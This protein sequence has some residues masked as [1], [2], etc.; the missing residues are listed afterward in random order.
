MHCP[1]CDMYSQDPVTC[2]HCG[3]RLPEAVT[4]PHA[5]RETRSR[6]S[7]TPVFVILALIVVAAAAWWMVS[8]TGGAIPAY[9][10]EGPVV[11]SEQ[12]VPGQTNIVDMYSEYCPPCRQIAPYLKKL[13]EAR[14]DIH[15]VK[16]DINRPDIRGID[17]QG[18]VAKQFKL[19]SIPHFILIS[20]EGELIAE[21]KTAYKQVVRMIEETLN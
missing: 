8:G 21:G 16:V 17:W 1:N 6:S 5:V 4:Q 12:I 7:I 20:P 15:V 11:L 14:D 19:R 3:T 18:P 10:N 9:M 13:D 2:S